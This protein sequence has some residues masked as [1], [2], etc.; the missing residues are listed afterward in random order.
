LIKA[1]VE[2][3][4]GEVEITPCESGGTTVRMW[5]PEADA[6]LAE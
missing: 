5:L 6:E 3:S 2:Q 4:G 1:V